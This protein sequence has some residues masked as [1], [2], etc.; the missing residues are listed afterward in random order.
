MNW[1]RY[2]WP[3]VGIAA[4]IFS[5]LLLWHELRGISLDDVWDGISAISAPGWILAALCSVIAYASLAGYD[6]IALLHI[7]KKVS[8][9]FVT[10]CSF[11]TYALSHNIGGSVFSGA[12]IRYRAYGTRGLSGQDVGVLVAICWITFVLSTIL[13][14]GLVLVF[15]PEI[16]DRFSGIAH[17]GLSKAAGIAMLIVVAAYIFGSWLHLRPLKIAGF[18]LHYPALPIVARQLLIGPIE[19]LAAAAIIFFALPAAHNPGYF[20][21]LGVFLV[22][23]SIAQISHAP[24]GLGVFEVVFLA[25]LS[26]MDPVGVLAALLVFRLFYLIIPLFLGLG[27]VLLFER[28][29]FS[30]TES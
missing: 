13:A 9:L 7:G 22:S 26:D 8:W 20:V 29:Q 28:S 19:L 23:F 4:V 18:Q 14:S 10:L 3:V 11:T 17:H 16:L 5:L 6:H 2:F 27:I 15:E 1:R 21:V 30:R 24:G 12:V 25:G